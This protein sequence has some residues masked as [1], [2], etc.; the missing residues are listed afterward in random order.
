MLKGW[1]DSKYDLLI[2]GYIYPKNLYKPRDWFYN[3]ADLMRANHDERVK[4]I[5]NN[6]IMYNQSEQEYQNAL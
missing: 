2:D 3:E 6:K 4:Q 1:G 5:F